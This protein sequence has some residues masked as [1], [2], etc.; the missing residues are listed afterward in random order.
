MDKKPPVAPSST[1]STTV[2]RPGVHSGTASGSGL[3]YPSPDLE[4]IE[5]CPSQIISGCTD[6]AMKHS[7]VEQRSEDLIGI[8]DPTQAASNMKSRLQRLAEQR[9]YWDSEGELES[10]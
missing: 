1:P 6:K 9:H 3:A 5:A 8:P 10:V 2:G 7:I 4:K